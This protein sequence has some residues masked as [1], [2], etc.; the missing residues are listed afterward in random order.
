VDK[1][2]RATHILDKNRKVTLIV[3]RQRIVTLVL[4]RVHSFIV[5]GLKQYLS[6]LVQKNNDFGTVQ[7]F[8]MDANGTRP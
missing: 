2:R 8:K 7:W 1:H 4:E 5:L 3:D 6:G